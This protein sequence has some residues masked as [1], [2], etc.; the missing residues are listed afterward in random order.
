M[1][2][3]AWVIHHN[4]IQYDTEAF[5]AYLQSY[6]TDKAHYIYNDSNNTIGAH[7]MKN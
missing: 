3:V 7:R 4:T 6:S 1:I 5:N 2:L